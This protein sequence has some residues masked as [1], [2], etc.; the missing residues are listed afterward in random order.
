[1]PVF[2]FPEDAARAV[3]HVVRYSSWR[4]TPAQPLAAPEGIDRDRATA[5]IARALAGGAGWLG[6][7]EVEELMTCYRL[8]MA[9]SRLARTAREAAHAAEAL[10]GPVALKA[11]SPGLLGKSK[12][13]GVALGI[14]GEQEIVRE[15][16]RIRRRLRGHARGVEGFVVQRMV[17]DG[18]EILIGLTND[19]SFGP[20]IAVGPVGAPD[21]A[22]ARAAVRI[23]PV[24][25]SDAQELVDAAVGFASEQ[26]DV[27]PDRE[28]LADV[29]ARVSALADGHPEVVEMDLH[30]VRIL[31]RGATI[32]DARVRVEPPPP[33]RPLFARR[34]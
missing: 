1:V 4:S 25:D 27:P 15:A 20:I 13:G 10:H 5:L 3:A 6:P 22:A 31:R 19:P 17:S 28:A 34:V 18:G 29:M 12:L 9:E 23:A 32:L 21:A 30:P 14:R 16:A 2:E 33:R 11:I 24:T 8:P 7:A 26:S